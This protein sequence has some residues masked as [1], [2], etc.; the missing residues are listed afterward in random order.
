MLDAVLS[1]AILTTRESPFCCSRVPLV[2]QISALG[3]IILEL[4]TAGQGMLER[5]DIE[6]MNFCLCK[7]AF[8]PRIRFVSQKEVAKI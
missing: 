5:I 3:Y 4:G 8:K 1:L 6:H 7:H 2:Q